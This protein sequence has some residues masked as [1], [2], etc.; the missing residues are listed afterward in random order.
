VRDE[1]VKASE[2]LSPNCS[3]RA[4]DG[5]SLSS[6]VGDVDGKQSASG[7]SNSVD[8]LDLRKS[9]VSTMDGWVCGL[10]EGL[11]DVNW[12]V[13]LRSGESGLLAVRFMILSGAVLILPS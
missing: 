11:T 6:F 2:D 8:A 1:A 7:V 9:G 3:D 13:V 10:E 5:E 12:K 4:K